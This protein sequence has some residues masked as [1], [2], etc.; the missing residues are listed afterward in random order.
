[1]PKLDIQKALN[2][3]QPNGLLSTAIQSFEP[4]EAQQEMMRN[5]IEA[6]EKNAI[7]LIEAGTG[8][9]KSFAYLIPALLWAASTKE[10]TLISTHTI[11]LQE[12]LIQKDIPLLLNALSLELK[13][14]LVKGMS[15][16]VCLRKFDEALQMAP[17][18]PPDEA[19]EIEKID[20]WKKNTRDGTRST[21]PIVPSAAVWEKIGAESDTCNHQQCPH[22]NS[23]FF[24]KARREASEAQI[25]VANHHLLFAD[26]GV[27]AKMDNYKDPSVLPPYQRIILDEAHHIE[28]VATKYFA[29]EA[30]Y[31]G[32]LRLLMRLA[33]DRQ[34]KSFGKLPLLKNI[35]QTHY[36][37]TPPTEVSNL[38]RKLN[39]DFF[40]IHQ[41]LILALN[42]TFQGY[43]EFLQSLSKREN[44]DDAPGENKL[45][46]RP[47]HRTH[48]L[49]ES[50]LVPRTKQ[51]T[52]GLRKYGQE[53]HALEK[54]VETLNDKAIQEKAKGIRFEIAALANRLIDSASTLDGFL[55]EKDETVSVRW[56]EA[57][58]ANKNI[59]LLHAELDM[60]KR[61]SEMLFSKFS[62]SI[63]CSATLTTNKEFAFIRRS[64]GLTEEHLPGKHV[65]AHIYDSPFDYQQQALFGIPTDLPNPADRDFTRKAVE[66]V[67]E[68][69]KASRG[70]A[71][72]LFTSYSMLKTCH[73]LLENRLKEHGFTTLKQGEATRQSLLATFKKTEKSVLFGTDSFWEGVDVV[74]DALRCVIIVK[75][76]F[77]VPSEPIIQAR[78]E[79]ISAKGGD[80]F[81]EY[82]LPQA[83]V[84]FKQGF[85][86]L[87][88][89]RRDRGCVI[90]LDTRL[91]QKG[92][93]KQFL[94]S[95]PDCQ[96][97]AEEG[98]NLFKQMAEFYRKTHYLTRK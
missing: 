85:G 68:A 65:S 21:L 63:L 56:I 71:F 6:Y 17:L 2:I 5:I 1:M 46:L 74:G 33:S 79:A 77:K 62:T 13:V 27:R 18:L 16:Y 29:S 96:Y 90:C 60:A 12:Q 43:L 20:A 70:N 8:T 93:G 39:I 59:H 88:R 44:A 48:P 76:P 84:K 45:R 66:V 23:C 31:I 11:N 54:E 82:T 89:N 67:W 30:S 14:V 24:V 35:L 42:Q 38:L 78:S 7:A 51:L 98:H 49:W 83:I 40:G 94:N 32:L 53:L 19:A 26:L 36:G 97:V 52:D 22:Y 80:P 86:R 95:L 64:L 57:S 73:L 28:E 87:I 34:G 15:N 81:M 9:G 4:R 92:Y 69:I 41:D 3:L 91:L 47:Y 37:V 75:L 25:L 58:G 50:H 72:V 10:R 61:L 55:A